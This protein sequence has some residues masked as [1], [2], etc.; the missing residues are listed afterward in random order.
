MRKPARSISSVS[1][2]HTVMLRAATPACCKRSHTAATRS[3]FVAMPRPPSVFTF[4]LTVSPGPAMR[5]HAAIVFLSAAV[6]LKRDCMARS[7]SASSRR[8]SMRPDSAVEPEPLSSGSRATTTRDLAAGACPSPVARKPDA[9][10]ATAPARERARK[11][12]RFGLRRSVISK[13]RRVTT[14]RKCIAGERL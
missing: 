1:R 8:E 7:R 11:F 2:S 10:N 4:R 6:K 5:R 14:S 13:L 9:P 3:I 12:R